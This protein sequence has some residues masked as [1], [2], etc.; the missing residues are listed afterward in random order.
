MNLKG[1][2]KSLFFLY[3]S[4]SIQIFILS[5]IFKGGF[6]SGGTNRSHSLPSPQPGPPSHL[7]TKV[8]AI[9]KTLKGSRS[10]APPTKSPWYKSKKKKPGAGFI[11]LGL[12]D[13]SRNRLV[14]TAYFVIISTIILGGLLSGGFFPGGFCPGGFLDGAFDRLP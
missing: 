10:K 3:L 6:F 9:L 1:G 14:S 7:R 8:P 2:F 11:F 12:V 13:P 4:N 5:L